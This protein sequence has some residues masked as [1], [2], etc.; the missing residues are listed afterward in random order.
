MVKCDIGMV[1]SADVTMSDNIGTEVSDNGVVILYIGM[2]TS[3]RG[4][5]FGDGNKCK[6]DSTVVGS[7]VVV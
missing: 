7:W 1:I 4:L 6:H 5:A 2:V 3:E